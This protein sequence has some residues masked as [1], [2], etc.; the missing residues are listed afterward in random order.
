[1]GQIYERPSYYLITDVYQIPR[2]I[3]KDLSK[4]NP[5]YF[6]LENI[7]YYYDKDKNEL[8]IPRGYSKIN[9]KRIFNTHEYIEDNNW[10]RNEKIDIGLLTPPKDYMQEYMLTFM[11]GKEPYSYTRGSTQ[12][13]IDMDTGG[14]KTYLGI[15]TACYFQA[16]CAIF[17]PAVSKISDQWKDTLN[18][19]TTLKRNEYLYVHGS[20]MCK[21]VINGKYDKVKIFII[22]RSTISSFVR[23]YDD[24]WNVVTK[25]VDAMNVDIKIIDEAHMDFS[26]IVRID[27]F[28]NVQKTYYM[29]SS[30]G[31]SENQEEYIYYNLFKNVPKHGKKLKS[32][33]QN[34]II[35][36]I[37]NFK[38]TP[39]PE[40]LKKIKTRYGTSLSK[41]ADYLLAD[42]GARDEF[43][44]A[45][46]FTVY[47]LLQFRRNGGKLLVIC[48]T[49]AFAK[50]LSEITK[51]LFPYLS[52]GLFVGSGK[53]KNKE[54][55]ADVVFSTTKGMGTG[56]EFINHQLTINT[57]TYASKI[58]ADQIS[59]RIRKQENRKGIY[60]EL[61]NI[62][63]KIAREHYMKREPYLIKKAKNGKII[64]HTITNEDIKLTYEFIDNKYKY[65][66]DG[67]VITSDNTYLIRRKRKK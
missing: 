39:T 19:F 20:E 4:W 53:D 50:E 37:I 44:E 15:A 10:A 40:W 48:A 21:D 36:L 61:V 54:L 66:Y 51:I 22:P 1:M 11:I 18:N 55:D 43:I 29:S 62:N 65:D 7:G 2:E 35:P 8:R 23:K 58:M 63:H 16:R 3:D 24:D 14:G 67:R 6:R 49:I 59:G 13:Y 42:D 46:A 41:Y 47:W 25:L 30:P 45:Y 32:K 9:I 5:G 57:L 27:C 56:S 33:E 60:C 26:T 12:L 17:I 52:M 64:T 38:S 34:H 31:R 28:T